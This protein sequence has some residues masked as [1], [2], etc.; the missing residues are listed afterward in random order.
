MAKRKTSF[1]RDLPA[2]M[3]G[4]GDG[5][6]PYKESVEV[7]DELVARYVASLCQQALRIA[8]LREAPV[9]AQCFVVAVKAQPKKTRRVMKLLDMRTRIKEARKT[10]DY[11]A[12]NDD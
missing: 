3:Y 2:M 8:A 11:D 4:F 1:A 7:V 12:Y 10:A 9:D 6:K 5:E